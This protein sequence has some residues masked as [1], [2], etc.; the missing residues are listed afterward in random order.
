MSNVIVIGAGAAG[1]MA[2]I[3]AAGNGHQVTVLEKNEK[4]GKKIYIT[5]KG[6]CNITN[7][8]DVEELFNNV[9]T[10]KKFLYSAFYGFTNDDVVTMLNTAGLATKVERGNRVFPVSDR[11]GDVI[12]ALVRI[13][14]KLGVKLEYDTTVTEIITGTLDKTDDTA[15][16][17]DGGKCGAAAG[18]IATTVTGVR[19]ASGK[20]YPADAVIVATGGVSYPTTG[21]TG[22]GYEFAQRTGH[23]VTALSPALV[24]FNVAEEDVKELQGLAL[25]NSGVTIYDGKKKLYE[26]FGELL[27]THFGVSGPTVLS[28]SSYV[29]KKIK[30]HPLRLV[31]D[32]KPGLDTEQLDA[33]VLRDFDEFMNKNFNN[34]LDKLL[35]KSLIPVVIRR[36]GIDEYKKVHEISR[37]ERLRLIGTIK[38]LEFTLTGLRGFNEA[39]I[40]QGGV[41]VRD[42]DPSTMESKKVGGLYFAGEVLDLDAVTGG[43]NLQ[44][45]WSTGHL[46]GM[47]V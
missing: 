29:A 8:C 17:A 30:D 37:E 36:S 4:A 32:L 9:V 46:A 47:S 19:C 31:I 10:N 20:V 42:I 43:F 24:P 27:F 6:R 11:A 39:I 16:A 34:A 41:S 28:A 44:I 12:A 45:A 3:A 18:A 15:D 33:R 40:T 5:G 23:N 21:S 38:N 14:K 26:D 7:A 1:M 25:K 22:D 35:P 13:M 2:A